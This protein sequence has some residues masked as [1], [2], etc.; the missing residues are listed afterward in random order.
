MNYGKI[1]TVL[2]LGRY[3]LFYYKFEVSEFVVS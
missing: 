1:N 3:Y 2:V